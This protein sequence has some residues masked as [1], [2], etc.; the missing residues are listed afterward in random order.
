MTV[1]PIAVVVAIALFA[2]K[3]LLEF[4]RRYRAEARRKE[5]IHALLARECEL[6]HWAIKSIRHIVM[7]VRDETAADPETKFS[8]VFPRSGKTLFRVIRKEPG[9]R[10]G[11][12]LA[13]V[14]REVM[15]KN[16]LEVAAIDKV[17]FAVL[18]PAYSAIANLEHVRASLTYYV[19]P[20][21]DQDKMHLEGFVEYALQELDGVYDDLNAL[22]RVCT[23]RKLE[24]HRVF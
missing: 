2:L 16:I 8:F 13:A 21:D 19:D 23:G 7:E 17:L 20:E 10:S 5:A 15:D 3:E 9:Y 22:Y 14:H 18:E 24:R 4:L 11:G 1:L 6:N 12:S